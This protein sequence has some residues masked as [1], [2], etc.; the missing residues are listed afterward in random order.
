VSAAF[1]SNCAVPG[2]ACP[3]M[4]L[5]GQ[6]L[7]PSLGLFQFT[8]PETLVYP[9]YHDNATGCTLVAVP[10]Q[11]YDITTPAPVLELPVIPDDGN[12]SIVE[13]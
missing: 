2:V 11:I 12:W 13:G 8:G 10:G 7:A 4:I 9:P 6:P 3:G 5:P 1:P